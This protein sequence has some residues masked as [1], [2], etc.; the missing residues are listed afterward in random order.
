[1]FN[2]SFAILIS[3]NNFT[4]THYKKLMIDHYV[5]GNIK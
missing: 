2:K 4:V 1:M 5:L 3:Y